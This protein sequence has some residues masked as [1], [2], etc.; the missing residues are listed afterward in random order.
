MT[1]H[2]SIQVPSAGD[3]AADMV[4]WST[5]LQSR[6]AA[7][8]NN[9]GQVLHGRVRALAAAQMDVTDYDQSIQLLPARGQRWVR[10]DVGTD[11]PAGYRHEFGFVGVDSRGRAYHDPPHPHFLPALYAVKPLFEAAIE[12]LAVP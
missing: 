4:R 3:V 7:I 2:V 1:L 8:T 9:Y 11:D 6:A 10:V 12:R 5:G